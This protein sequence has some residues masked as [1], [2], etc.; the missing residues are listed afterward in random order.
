M[1]TKLN[2]AATINTGPPLSDQLSVKTCLSSSLW[3][4]VIFIV[5]NDVSCQ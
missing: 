3:N 4:I 1:I 5:H 2:S